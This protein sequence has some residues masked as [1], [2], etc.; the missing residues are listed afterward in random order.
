M[1]QHFGDNERLAHFSSDDLDEGISV[2]HGAICGLSGCT[3]CVGSRSW[4]E[5]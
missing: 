2:G 1:V 5:C 3:C 4:L